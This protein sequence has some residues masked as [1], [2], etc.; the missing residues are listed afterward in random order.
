MASK[1]PSP[2]IPGDTK[3]RT[4]SRGILRRAYAEVNRR[5][6]GLRKDVLAIFDG[7]RAYTVN[8]TQAEVMYGLTPDELAATAQGLQ[9]ALDRWIAE[10]RETKHI[11]WWEPYQSDAAQAGAAQSVANLSRLSASYAASRTL[12]DVVFSE[13]Y[14]NRLAMAQVR[15]YEQWTSLSQSMRS[16]LS[17][18]IGR[19][20]VDGKNPKA[21]RGE[22]MERLDVSKSRAMLYAQTDVTNTLRETRMAEADYAGEQYGLELRLLWTSALLPTT[23]P[24][25]ASRNGKAYTTDD[26]RQF[27][28]QKG[29]RFRCHCGVTECLVDDDGRPQISDDAKR[30]FAKERA[31]WEKAQTQ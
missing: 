14:R 7:I 6:A 28:E 17:Q 9:D 25:H 15:S 29:N 4:G 16:E 31:A 13:P 8:R 24:H 1:P 30:T 23:R 3:D 18:I 20:V 27:Y 5:F 12:R 2:I 10:G 21:V 19:A 22:I 11:L 26:V